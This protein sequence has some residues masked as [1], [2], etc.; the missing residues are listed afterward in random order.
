MRCVVCLDYWTLILGS[1]CLILSKMIK[2]D[3]EGGVSLSLLGVIKLVREFS[4]VNNFFFFLV[5]SQRE[6][7][8]A[9]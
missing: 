5:L 1:T 3:E 2:E 4:G 7:V 8:R 9:S 6:S